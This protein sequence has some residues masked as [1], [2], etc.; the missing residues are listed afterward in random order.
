MKDLHR[1]AELA[2]IHL[3]KK[4]LVSAPISTAGF[5]V[6]SAAGFP[7]KPSIRRPR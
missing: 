7:A 1:K 3:V 6:E 2:V 4:E 5:S